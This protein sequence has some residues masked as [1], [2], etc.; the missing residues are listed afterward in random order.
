MKRRDF[1]KK[2]LLASGLV[3]MGLASASPA[4]GEQH[5]TTQ[6]GKDYRIDSYCHF[7]VM[8]VI[9][10]L[11]RASNSSPHIFRNLFANTPTLIHPDKRL[12]LMDSC[13]IDLSVLV[14]L[15]WL[16]T[17]P[18]VHANPKLCA[19]AARLFNDELATIVNKRPDRFAGVALL[20]TTNPEVMLA[21]FERAVRSLKLVGGF[22][23]VGPTVKQPDHPDY[24]HLYQKAVE[25]GVPLWVHPSRP[26][27]YPDYVG[28]KISQYQVWQTLSWLLDSSTAMVRL[29]FSGV[30]ERYP[31]LKLIIHHHGAL[32]PLFAKR[33]QYGWDYFEQNT[34]EKQATPI[35]RPYINHFKKFYCDTATQGHEP[36]L[37]KMAYDFFGPEK[38]LFGSDAPMDQTG[39]K[40]FTMDARK[41]VEDLALSKEDQGKIF[42]ENIQRLLKRG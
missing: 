23:V 31:D 25:L 30:Y 40:A 4:R 29:V 1:L 2:A 20:P 10:F 34:G 42:S 41:S 11:E 38:M 14:P 16:E 21:E 5:K 37:L 13:G 27:V 36:L 22:F 9:D 24:E 15:P 18:P 3:S 26:P 28:E 35:S 32:V 19:E 12:A 8:R 33:M 39:G 6:S 17:T 7:S